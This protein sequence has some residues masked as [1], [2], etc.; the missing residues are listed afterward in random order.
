MNT[1]YFRGSTVNLRTLTIFFWVFLIATAAL[2]GDEKKA[3][4]VIA[5]DGDD[6]GKQVM[7]FVGDDASTVLDDLEVG[8]LPRGALEQLARRRPDIGIVLYRNLAHGLGT[9]LRR[10]DAQ[11]VIP[12]AESE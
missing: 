3:E 1:T 8:V 4:I 11:V 9:K 2:A 10:A 12:P 6:G 5:V 7:R